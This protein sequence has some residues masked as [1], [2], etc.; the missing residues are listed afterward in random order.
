MQKYH[1]VLRW[2]FVEVFLFTTVGINLSFKA[3]TG[4]AQSY[5]GVPDSDVAKLIEILILG[6]MG[7]SAG[8]LGIECTG[9][10]TLSPHRRTLQYMGLWWL[11]TW[12]FQ[13]P[14]ATVQAT[15]GSLPLTMQIIPGIDGLKKALFIQQ[16]SAFA[17]LFM[18]PIG[19]FLT[20][21]VGKPIA[22]YLAKLDKEASS[23]TVN[24]VEPSNA[25]AQ[26]E[27]GSPTSETT[28]VEVQ[29]ASPMA[30]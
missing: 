17:V 7:R 12:I 8:I 19:V 13:M 3:K 26:I 10:G 6:S 16:A 29:V 11:C 18:A 9:F 1:L 2:V 4:P 5:R 22:E 21:V 25:K 27:L 14:K 30:D 20:N 28:F 23:D 15:L 24:G